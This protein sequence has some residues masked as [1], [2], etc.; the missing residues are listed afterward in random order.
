MRKVVRLG[1]LAAVTLGFA[2]SS[3]NAALSASSTITRQ[4]LGTGDFQYTLSLK[5]T[6][7]T[8][9]GTLWFGWIPGYDLL[10]HAP[11]SIVAPTGWTG[12]NAPDAF[13][14]AS[15]RWVT[16]TAPLQPGQTLGGFTFDSPDA[17]ITTG[18]SSFFSLPIDQS[19]VY[20]G[21]PETDPGF[22]FTPTVVSTPEPLSLGVLAMPAAALL[23]RRRS[24]GR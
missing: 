16:T 14:V 4:Q 21:A 24:S 5:D 18:T 17:N 20:I 3:V 1:I 2:G 15:A 22:A 9:I 12:L 13:G 11:T 6:G 8:P 7:T 23:I 19:Y 10:P